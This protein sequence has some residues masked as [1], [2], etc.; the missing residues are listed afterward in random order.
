MYQ[1][2]GLRKTGSTKPEQ[3]Y[4]LILKDLEKQTRGYSH[5]TKYGSEAQVRE[6]LKNGGMNDTEIDAYFG[7]AS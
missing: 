7:R 3:E 4:E 2:L 6:M 1:L 5:T